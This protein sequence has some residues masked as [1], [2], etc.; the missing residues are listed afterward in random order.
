MVF[1]SLLFLC[2][3]LRL[4]Y[5]IILLCE[6]NGM[7]VIARF[8]QMPATETGGKGNAA[9]KDAVNAVNAIE[10]KE[11]KGYMFRKWVDG[12]QGMNQEMSIVIECQ[13]AHLPIR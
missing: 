4:R 5:I 8:F 10:A 6:F 1:I 2:F 7:R 11:I 3:C 12:G 9:V 13:A